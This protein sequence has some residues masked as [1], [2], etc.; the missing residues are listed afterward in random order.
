M[1]NELLR[2]LHSVKELLHA[3]QLR[4]NALEQRLQRSPN[5]PVAATP[6]HPDIP[7]I[8]P[9]TVSTPKP[10]PAPALS[11]SDAASL[12]ARIGR[13]WLNRIGIVALVLGIAFFILYTFQYLGAWAKLAIGFTVGAALVGGGGWLERRPALQ[14][15]ARGLIG[16]GW[17]VLY[18]TVYA[19]HHLPTVR[20]L[21]SSIV[22]LCLLSIVAAGATWQSLKYHSQTIT[23]LALLL[24]F[25]T[26]CIGDVT[27]FT[28]ASS[29]LLVAA[30]AWLVMKLH[31]DRLFVYGVAASYATYLLWISP[32]IGFSRIIALHVPSV[33]EAEFWLKAGFLGLYWV[34]YHIAG[35]VLAFRNPVEQRLLATATAINGLAFVWGALSSMDVAY[36]EW[37]YLVPC[38]V[39]AG[40]LA[41]AALLR[42]CGLAQLSDTSI[43]LGLA[44][45]TLAI[46]L[47]LTGRW[48]DLLWI[49]EVPLLAWIGLRQDRWTYRLVA[50]MVGVL[51]WFRF[52]FLYL[53]YDGNLAVGSWM[54]PWR[55]WMGG[56][57]AAAYGLAAAGY[58]H[59]AI[60]PRP[61]EAPAFH[62][63][64]LGAT[65][66]LWLVV[67]VE[68]QRMWIG[69]WW[70]MES[71]GLTLLGWRL[72]DRVFRMA[73]AAVMAIAGG[74]AMLLTF[75]H[76]ASVHFFG[77]T[78]WPAVLTIALGYGISMAY[79]Q[80]RFETGDLE[81]SLHTAYAVGA[82]ILLTELLWA[83]ARH[84]WLS[85]ALSFEG[86]ALVT[87]G[88]WRHDR[89][90]RSCG[91]G[92]FAALILKILLIDMAGAETVYRILSF[93]AAGVVLLGV[94]YA[95]ARWMGKSESSRHGSNPRP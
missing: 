37:R 83:D 69:G 60:T 15:Y 43:L 68:A 41:S 18:F 36:Q 93:I 9:R 85:V 14:W 4:V 95:Y 20:V 11:T 89:V 67:M 42:R 30:L 63:Y 94:S 59:M 10:P 13:D 72:H 78:R 77:W 66:V 61:R 91:L 55:L 74:Y 28:L 33:T 71:V 65:L 19:M 51:V 79:R 38:A 6:S 82:T 86:L 8:S 1:S 92:V 24:G 50:F 22:D 64:G 17:A 3:L 54:V 53:W 39:G 73:G 90:L 58:R 21:N 48:I 5:E 57:L 12:E 62:I 47:K 27:Y 7:P 34:V 35:L 40:Y 16:G 26:I 32:R 31:W 23:A 76:V 46:P 52:F 81:R 87:I 49:F 44:F 70:A 45:V 29:V 80:R 2:E 88:F 25:L 84:Q 56:F 75:Y